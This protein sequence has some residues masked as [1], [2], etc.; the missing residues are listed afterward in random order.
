MYL[1]WKDKIVFTTLFVISFSNYHE[2]N[3]GL[4]NRQISL[5][6]YA[7]YVYTALAHHFDRCDVALKGK[8]IEIN[9]FD[10]FLYK[11]LVQDTMNILKKWLKKKINMQINSWN[12]KMNVVVQSFFWIS[13]FVDYIH[14]TFC[15]II[16]KLETPTAKLEFASRSFWNGF[17]IG[18]RC[19]SSIAW[20]TYICLPT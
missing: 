6:L 9:W 4:V 17:T 7:S 3:E 11:I 18:K 19:L 20:I 12:I 15:Y 13:K 1:L 16:K 10:F 14:L 2:D 5:E 8:K